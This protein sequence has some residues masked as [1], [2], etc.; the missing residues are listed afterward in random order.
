[1]LAP[2]VSVQL[3]NNTSSSTSAE[4]ITSTVDGAVQNVSTLTELLS[5]YGPTLVILAVFI[6][7]F[8]AYSLF[9]I[10][11]I[12]SLSNKVSSLGDKNQD[13]SQEVIN[14]ILDSYLK[15]KED[16]NE[17]S[18]EEKEKKLVSGFAYANISMND[19]SRIVMGDIRCDRVGV[20]VFH[21][22]NQTPYGFP[23][24]KMTCI[25]EFSMKGNCNTIRGLSHNGMP[26]HV[27]PT[28]VESLVDN[29][30]YVIGNIFNH[31]LINSNEEIMAFI[32]GSPVKALFAL[33]IKTDTGELAAFTVAEFKDEKD[34]SDPVVYNDVKDALDLMNKSIRSIVIDEKFK[35]EAIQ[36]RGNSK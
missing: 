32:S 12:I 34:F 17:E 30:E 28:F 29:G 16:K 23:F 20:Y 7:L 24:V 18:E 6:F 9:T 5:K 4:A 14:K 26:L 11:M 33:A 21:N 31:G 2:T 13:M 27:M 8:L 1:M 19:A 35:N 36:H 3:L 10:K 25:N 15:Q 22:G